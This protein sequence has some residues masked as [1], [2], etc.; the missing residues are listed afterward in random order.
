VT[1]FRCPFD[2]IESVKRLAANFKARGLQQF[3]DSGVNGGIIVNNEN[4]V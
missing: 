2:C 4:A 3:S 1:Y